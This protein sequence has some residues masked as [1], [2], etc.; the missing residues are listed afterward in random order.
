MRPRLV[1][2]LYV[3]NETATFF[4]VMRAHQ[5]AVEVVTRLRTSS[6]IEVV[7]IDTTLWE[8][9]WDY[10]VRNH[11]KTYSVTDCVSFVLMHERKL[12]T[13]LTFGHHFRQA[14]FQTEPPAG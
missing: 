11:D 4:N 6:S 13:A 3:I 14:G 2:T 1:T 10:F 7:D 12:T 8:T 9:G 5:K